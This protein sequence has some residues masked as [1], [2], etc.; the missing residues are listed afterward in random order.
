[1]SKTFFL[2]FSNHFKPQNPLSS[3]IVTELCVKRWRKLQ[4]QREGTTD[5]WKKCYPKLS[6]TRPWLE[7]QIRASVA[8]ARRT[9]GRDEINQN[10]QDSRHTVGTGKQNK[11][12]VTC[13]VTLQLTKCSINLLSWW[14]SIFSTIA[15]IFTG[16]FGKNSNQCWHQFAEGKGRKM[17]IKKKNIGEAWPHFMLWRNK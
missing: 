2:V 15:R 16:G 14:T 10:S 4:L 12:Y 11:A 7:L 3:C 9:S 6:T 8:M 1:M 5:G 17:T 13:D